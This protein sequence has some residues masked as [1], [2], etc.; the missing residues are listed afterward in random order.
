MKTLDEKTFSAFVSS[1]TDLGCLLEGRGV[2]SSSDPELDVGA[3]IL[4]LSDRTGLG[5]VKGALFELGSTKGVNCKIQ[6]IKLRIW[7]CY[8]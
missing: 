6:R 4:S 2:V 3:G 1:G 5:V 7:P 8:L